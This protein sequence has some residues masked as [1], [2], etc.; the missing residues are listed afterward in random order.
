MSEF[1]FKG[2][3]GEWFVHTDQV[4][5]GFRISAEATKGIAMATQRDPHPLNGGAISWDEARCNAQLIAA[6]PELFSALNELLGHVSSVQVGSV[7]DEARAA[8]AKAT[9]QEHTH[10]H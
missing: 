3:P 2:T 10:D 1:E 6:A 9:G 8:L 4:G 7:Y 5:G